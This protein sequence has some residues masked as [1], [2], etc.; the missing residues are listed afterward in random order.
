MNTIQVRISC[1]D[2]INIRPTRVN[3]RLVAL[4]IGKWKNIFISLISLAYNAS[5][6]KIKFN[7]RKQHKNAFTRKHCPVYVNMQVAASI[8]T[9]NRPRTCNR[10][11][12]FI[13]FA[14]DIVTEKPKWT[15]SR[16]LTQNF[17][18]FHC[19]CTAAS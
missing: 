3:R 12:S 4:M 5:D 14:F 17:H 1:F 8:V 6:L 19:F 7:F 10:T 18:K 9:P 16:K 15:R 11:I 13:R 2:K